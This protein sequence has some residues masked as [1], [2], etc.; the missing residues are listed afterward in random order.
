MVDSALFVVLVIGPRL[1]K[2]KTAPL[3]NS[4]DLT[5]HEL[6]AFAGEDGRPA[7]IAFKGI[8]Y[9]VSE[10][11][12]WRSGNHMKRHKAGIDLTGM[13]SQAPHKEDKVVVMPQVG[14][15]SVKNNN[16]AKSA[17]EKVFYFMAYMNLG[18]VFI[19]ALILSLWRWL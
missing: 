10:S 11:K 8:I 16:K 17:H 7:Y 15:L 2:K 1:K 4:T 12:L 6:N 3:S 13:L 19:I 9:D 18:F 5:L 14:K